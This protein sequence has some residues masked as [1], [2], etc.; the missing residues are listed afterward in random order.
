MF[1]NRQVLSKVLPGANNVP[2][3]TVTSEMNCTLSQEDGGIVGV[4]EGTTLVDVAVGGVPVTVA[5]GVTIVPP[6]REI[7]GFPHSARSLAA[8]P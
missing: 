4:F 7:I 1:F 6:V 5:V 2:S 3:G 8:E